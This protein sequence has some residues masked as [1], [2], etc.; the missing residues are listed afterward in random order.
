MFAR[1]AVA[2]AASADLV[3]EGAIDLE[4]IGLVEVL[5]TGRI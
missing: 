2:V 5:E 4:N 1:T 3:V